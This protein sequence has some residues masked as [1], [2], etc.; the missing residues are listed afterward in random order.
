M[1]LAGFNLWGI[2]SWLA[3]GALIGWVASV[4]FGSKGG[5]LKYIFIGIVGSALGGVLASIFNK[6]DAGWLISFIFSVL[7]AGI[8]IIILRAFK[9]IR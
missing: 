4:F 5:I 1:L 7:G 6:G 3:M 8:L 9:L 2:L